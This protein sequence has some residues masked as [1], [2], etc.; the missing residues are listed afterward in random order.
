MTG[1]LRVRVVKAKRGGKAQAH[2]GVAVVRTAR[3]AAQ[4]GMECCKNVSGDLVVDILRA[5][6]RVDDAA[7]VFV[8]HIGAEFAIE[9][10]FGRN[11]EVADKLCGHGR[12]VTPP[13]CA[14]S[15][16]LGRLAIRH[17]NGDLAAKLAILSGGNAKESKGGR[18]DG[19]PGSIRVPR[20][21][22]GVP[23]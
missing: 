20:V 18:R 21:R 2:L 7:E 11:E 22:R 10:I 13:A 16:A 14:T 15:D 19:N 6:H 17:R 4:P 9:I 12:M 1:D 5:G 3:L 8:L 23:Q